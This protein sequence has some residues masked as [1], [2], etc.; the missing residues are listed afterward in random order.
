MP[1]VYFYIPIVQFCP[2]NIFTCTKVQKPSTCI[3]C[4]ASSTVPHSSTNLSNWPNHLCLYRCSKLGTVTYVY[5]I[6]YPKKHLRHPTTSC[7]MVLHKMTVIYYLNTNIT[8][9]LIFQAQFLGST[10]SHA[11]S[12]SRSNNNV[13]GATE[14]HWQVSRCK[15][16]AYNLSLCGTSDTIRSK[17][18]LFNNKIHQGQLYNNWRELIV[19]TNT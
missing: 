10:I 11:M 14:H 16:Q 3:L 13:T 1:V 8:I 18:T 19:Q 7:T 5:T 2:H 6:P 15:C 9:I 17:A 12:F 4:S